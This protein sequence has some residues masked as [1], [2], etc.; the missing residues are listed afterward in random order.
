MLSCFPQVD[1][2]MIN[3]DF[4]MWVSHCHPKFT[5]VSPPMHCQLLFLVSIHQVCSLSPPLIFK[6][7][8]SLLVLGCLFLIFVKIYLGLDELCVLALTSFLQLP[9][10]TSPHLHP[11]PIPSLPYN[12]QDHVLQ[13]STLKFSSFSL[14]SK[15]S[16]RLISFP[17][18]LSEFWVK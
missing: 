16:L 2:Y 4:S 10:L 17:D 18:E 6:C 9:H 3:P 13:T 7:P 12:R 1:F 15:F 8:L 14:H 5:Y 11:C